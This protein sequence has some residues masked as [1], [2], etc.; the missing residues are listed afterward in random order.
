M[1]PE[2]TLEQRLNEV[3]RLYGRVQR[4]VERPCACVYRLDLGLPYAVKDFFDKPYGLQKTPHRRG[5]FCFLSARLTSCRPCRPFLP[6]RPCHRR[7]ASTPLSSWELLLP[8][9]RW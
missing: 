7:R 6:C 3:R 5:F 9:I 2:L 4:L 8:Y 1:R